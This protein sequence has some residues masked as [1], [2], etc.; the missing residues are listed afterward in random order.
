MLSILSLAA[1]AAAPSCEF[2][3]TQFFAHVEIYLNVPGG[4]GDSIWNSS[5]FWAHD[6]E[7][8]RSY[9]S[10]MSALRALSSGSYFARYTSLRVSAKDITYT[11]DT[12]NTCTQAAASSASVSGSACTGSV[13]PFLPLLESVNMG[14]SWGAKGADTYLNTTTL[15]GELVD[16]FGWD[17]MC[18]G[19]VEAQHR[20]YVSRATGMPVMETQGIEMSCSSYPAYATLRY[21]I[22][23]NIQGS[24]DYL[25]SGP[26]DMFGVPKQCTNASAAA[27]TLAN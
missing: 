7:A 4:G 21:T 26:G 1:A 25:F 11:V 6:G 10:E 22:D 13:L 23:P 5:G 14:S 15:E 20:V 9:F 8:Q 3:T 18:G 12:D 2:K 19:A 17:Y 24:I 16:V 27:K